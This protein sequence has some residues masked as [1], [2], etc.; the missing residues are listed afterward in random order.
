[1]ALLTTFRSTLEHQAPL[2]LAML[3]LWA[4][5]LLSCAWLIAALLRRA[6]PSLRY[7]V[8]QFALMGLLALPALF[9]LFPG[10]PLGYS[11]QFAEQETPAPSASDTLVVAGANSAAA[12]L[13]SGAI[14]D[15]RIPAPLAELA[16]GAGEPQPP[17]D[18]EVD[19]DAHST[20][21]L[22]LEAPAIAASLQNARSAASPLISWLVVLVV[23]WGIGVTAQFVWLLRGIQRAARLTRS[24]VPL[25]DHRITQIQSELVERFA[26]VRSARLLTSPK[27]PTPVVMG[28][29]RPRVLLPVSAIDWADAKIRLVL[30][31]ELAHVERRDIFWQLTARAATALYW[32]HPL[33]WLALW[34]MREERERACDDRVLAI[35]VPAID[36]A[37]GLVEVAAAL[38]GR[39]AR[40]AG[41]VGIAERL[42][43]E[44]RVRSILDTTSPRR[45]ASR[46]TRGLLLVLTACLVSAIGVLRPFSPVTGAAAV[47]SPPK[48]DEAPAAIEAPT[49][50]PKAATDKAKIKDEPKQLAT[51]GSMLIR[52]VGPDDQPVAGAKLF[53]NV[54]H[55]DRA[56]K[57]DKRRVI[58]NNDYV[59]GPDGTVEI[60]LP[61]L[62]E[63]I[64]LW[65]RKDGYAPMFAIWWPKEQPDLLAIPQE[66]TY[67]LVK[68]TIL[69]GLVNDETG[70]PIERVK[71]EVQYD[72][73]GGGP[74]RARFDSWLSQG[75]DAIVT[76]AQGRWM[77][78]NVP[79]GDDIKVRVKLSHPDF[80]SDKEWG[81]FQQE[82]HIAPKALRAQSAVMVLKRGKAITGKVTDPDGQPV[83]NTI[84]I[85]GDRPYWEH[86]PHQ[87]VRTDEQG[88]YRFP[89][90]P[91]GEMHVTVVAE[92]WMPQRIKTR[93]APD[94]P[95][96]DFALQPGKKLR[97]RFVDKSGSPVPR[98]G[99]DIASWRGAESLHNMKASQVL[100]TN[101]PR[102]AND[103]GVY[104]W[105]W[106]PDDAVQFRFGK[107]GYA[108]VE[109][110]ITADD[111]EHVVTMN[112]PL[113]FVG[114]VVDAQSGGPVKQFAAVPMIFFRPDFPSVDHHDAKDFTDGEFEMEFDRGD[115][116]HG[117]QIEAAGYVTQRVGPYPIGA[118]PPEFA[119]KLQP[120]ERFV[121][122]VVDEAGQPVAR[123]RVYVGSYS[124][125]LYLHDLRAEDGG[126]T[127]NYS[128][129]TDD[130]GAFEIAHQLER[131]CLIVVAD[132]GYAE[133]DRPLGALPGLLRLERWA[134]VNG[135]LMQRGK[136]IENCGIELDPI[137]DAGGDAP[138]G[139]IRFYAKTTERGAFVF[140]R[141]PPVP[142]RVE[143][144][145]HWS[146]EGPLSSSQSIPLDPAPGEQLTVALGA[147]GA[148]VT[149][150]LTLD[151]PATADFD[152]HFGLNYLVARK[153]GIAPPASIAGRGFDWRKGW[154]DSWTASTEGAVYLQTLPHSYV[155]PD[156]D[157]K[158]R[159]S[160]VEPGEYDLAFRLYGS[161]EGCLV[162]PVAMAV[163]RVNVKEGQSTLDLGLIKVPAVPGLKMGDAAPAFEFVDADGRKQSLG[164]SRGKYVLIDFW[165][166]WCGPCVAGI[167]Q[168]ESLRQKHAERLGLMVVGANLDQDPQRA[169][170]FLRDRKVPWPHALLGDW[171]STAT[172]KRFAVASI[173][174][175]ILIGPDG[176]VLAH[177]SSLDAIAL[178]LEKVSSP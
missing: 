138:R 139:T 21:E 126:R 171:S 125:H 146:V 59:T 37:T 13:E 68:G 101:I 149:G 145:I 176:N 75:D 48:N 28:A 168:V 7:C 14:A 69:G 130:T 32:F 3:L 99:V 19:N 121:G 2:F 109:T 11:L 166:T 40:I 87:E 45:P 70:K 118:E 169:K 34:R 154:S 153:A 162:H 107:E 85:W 77:L 95:A 137:R 173:P 148:E 113:R 116:E 71:V 8:W 165:A 57:S 105:T 47:G 58:K 20:A 96:V 97:L 158:F 150:R 74:N 141:V 55:W 106:A 16:T 164:Q 89:P 82:Q 33:A 17:R 86:R 114:S 73:D 24:A 53:A 1:M 67:R 18:L 100:D 9:A 93:I 178:I 143:A 88:V 35:G 120:T 72:G 62:V 175:Y 163:V 112:P 38:A 135:Q 174:T 133:A 63:D 80:I 41:A 160:G 12:N 142:C 23:V 147:K 134:K 91:P 5:L 117:L 64:R 43:L 98:V 131:Y 103:K 155:K 172:P 52:V 25:N 39:P 30:A 27:A 90:L 132:D 54:S 170:D 6:S 84:V 123:A 26:L 167:P 66:F 15:P 49:V 81:Q 124:E 136:P 4:S 65:V 151:P 92:G 61:V 56:A 108:N 119:L 104:E 78:S 36:Y 156:P 76:D 127:D 115:V 29:L 46:R 79:P 122:R 177:E 161:T 111:S 157:G 44:D 110:S 10:V 159:I 129:K 31:H 128:V 152:Y 83:K 42:P 140:D 60:T 22:P 51:K 102:R 144:S 50:P 94:A